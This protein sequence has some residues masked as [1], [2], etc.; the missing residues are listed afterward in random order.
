MPAGARGRDVVDRLGLQIATGRLA[1]GQQIVP[2]QVAAEHGVARSVVREALRVLESKGL[3]RPRQRTGTRVLGVEEWDV[4]DADVISW[5]VAGPDR[6]AVLADLVELRVAV[7]PAAARLC[8]ARATPEQ[9]SELAAL[10]SRMRALGSAGDL[11]G[12]T[13][14]DV[15]FHEL[16]L[17]ASGNGAFARLRSGFAGLL[18]ARE[19]LGTLPH[20][21][22]EQVL[23][24]HERIAEAVRDGDGGGAERA[25]RELIE[26]ADAE[27]RARLV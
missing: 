11:A 9:A 4:L 1:V 22:D 21:I 15:A 19:D 3:V 23:A 16:L 25:A 24:L 10:A 20:R 14:A 7:E 18:H 6:D 8:C 17:V 26:G 12:F 27:L 13:A 5:R 2:E